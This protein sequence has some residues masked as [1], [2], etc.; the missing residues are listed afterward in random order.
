MKRLNKSQHGASFVEFALGAFV[1]FLLLFGCISISIYLATRIVVTRALDSTLESLITDPR[2]ISLSGEEAHS[3]AWAR[4]NAARADALAKGNRLVEASWVGKMLIPFTLTG[5]SITSKIQVLRPD[6]QGSGSGQNFFDVWREV[7]GIR[8]VRYSYVSGSNCLA[9]PSES[10]AIISSRCPLMAHA[11]IEFTLWPFGKITL[12]ITTYQFPELKDPPIT[13][14]A[15]PTLAP[16][17]TPTLT[18]TP[19]A[20]PGGGQ[21]PPPPSTPTATPTPT[22]VP[23]PPECIY[24]S[25]EAAQQACC[26]PLNC[27]HYS[28]CYTQCNTT[29]VFFRCTGKCDGG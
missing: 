26:I 10:Y 16:Y 12:P 17:V 24:T 21:P 27:P 8:N 15:L 29:P 22:P 25:P 23:Q 14:R 6:S 2:F 28:V 19:T 18:N 5:S 20:T 3:E 1:F 13:P 4:V 9:T 11:L 7:G